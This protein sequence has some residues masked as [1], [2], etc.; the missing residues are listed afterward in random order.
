M[1]SHSE[2]SKVTVNV[3]VPFFSMNIDEKNLWQT[4]LGKPTI[5]PA[6]HKQHTLL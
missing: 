4:Q 2:L 6:L 1:A 5:C 3:H